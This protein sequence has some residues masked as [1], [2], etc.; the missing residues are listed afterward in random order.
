M[1]VGSLCLPKDII[2]VFNNHQAAL[3]APLAA[4]ALAEGFAEGLLNSLQRTV[5]RSGIRQRIPRGSTLSSG[6]D[7]KIL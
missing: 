2:H 5:L 4:L 6:W 3:P 7:L 1:D